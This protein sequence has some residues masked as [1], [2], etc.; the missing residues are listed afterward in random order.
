MYLSMKVILNTTDLVQLSY[1]NLKNKKMQEALWP[2][3]FSSKLELI[4][5][6]AAL[7]SF[8]V[9][10]LLIPKLETVVL[11]MRFVVELTPVFL[12]PVKAYRFLDSLLV[13]LT[14]LT[15]VRHLGGSLEFLDFV[16]VKFLHTS[17]FELSCL[18]IHL[19][20]AKVT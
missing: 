20:T 5:L 19:G 9:S 1:P 16:E 13:R 2:L 17:D 7:E 12:Y 10:P 14:L 6:R 15:Q 11:A 4:P 18:H 8:I 3:A